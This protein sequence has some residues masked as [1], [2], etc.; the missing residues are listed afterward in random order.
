MGWA[1]VTVSEVSGSGGVGGGEGEGDGG[2]GKGGG[3]V[4]VPSSWGLGYSDNRGG[5]AV[6]VRMEAVVGWEA[7][8]SS[9]NNTG[10]SSSFSNA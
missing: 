6:A 10:E 7:E 9:N 8:R 4:I 5:V 3:E 2:E 1:T